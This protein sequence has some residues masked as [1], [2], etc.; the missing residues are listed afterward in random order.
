[1]SVVQEAVVRLQIWL[2]RAT[3]SAKGQGLVEYSLIL[4]FVAI[5]T[6]ASLKYLQPRIS[7]T[8]NSVSSNL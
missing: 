7:T 3:E 4:A 8:L 5:L 2:A 6:L 1:M